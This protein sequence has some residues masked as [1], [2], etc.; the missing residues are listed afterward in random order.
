MY[1]QVLY[2]SHIYIYNIYGITHSVIPGTAAV[3]LSFSF[4]GM[5]AQASE[6]ALEVHLS[7]VS[8]EGEEVPSPDVPTPPSGGGAETP[9]LG[10]DAAET[11][12]LGPV[13]ADTAEPE[14]GPFIALPGDGLVRQPSFHRRATSG[15]LHPLSRAAS[16]FLSD[17]PLERRGSRRRVRQ[18]IKRGSTSSSIAH[19]LSR[20][21]THSEVDAGHS[22]RQQSAG[23]CCQRESSSGA[24]WNLLRQSSTMMR[25]SLASSNSLHERESSREHS[26]ERS[27]RRGGVARTDFERVVATAAADHAYQLRNGRL[28]SRRNSSP[29]HGAPPDPAAGPKIEWSRLLSMLQGQCAKPGSMTRSQSTPLCG[30]PGE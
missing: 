29:I 8:E 7:H 21:A 3:P 10:P 1:L 22:S 23:S 9:A 27:C 2:M 6:V 30:T 26:R 19:P 20:G 28:V 14:V 13:D 17:D 18:L 16:G 15:S 5:E 4:S 25:S 12:A 24:H 11:P